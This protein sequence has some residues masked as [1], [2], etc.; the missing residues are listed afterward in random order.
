M[1]L[2]RIL[3]TL[4]RPRDSKT[5]S[6]SWGIVIKALRVTLEERTDSSLARMR[7]IVADALADEFTAMRERAAA[8][9]DVLAKLAGVDDVALPADIDAEMSAIAARVAW[10]PVAEAALLEL[11]KAATSLVQ[12]FPRAT[13][14]PTANWV[15]TCLTALDREAFVEDTG[16]QGQEVDLTI[17]RAA[18]TILDWPELAANMPILFQDLLLTVGATV[19]GVVLAEGLP[20]VLVGQTSEPPTV[21]LDPIS[22]IFTEFEPDD[23]VAVFAPEPEFAVA[24]V[25]ASWMRAPSRT[26]NTA[27]LRSWRM[28][29]PTTSCRSRFQLQVSRNRETPATRRQ[30]SERLRRSS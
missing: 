16:L 8:Q 5:R 9:V 27:I 20:M 21:E 6:A 28:R 24:L 17:W 18:R 19:D 26:P 25:G 23:G 10:R 14:L 29:S 12:P 3:G 30:S 13:P 15:S 2:L 4:E 22:V 1:S 7:I 11:L